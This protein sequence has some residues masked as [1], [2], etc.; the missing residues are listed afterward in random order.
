MPDAIRVLKGE[1][2]PVL[3][4]QDA[5][6][7]TADNIDTFKPSDFYGPAAEAMK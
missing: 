7:V 2:I 1:A 3:Q 5:V 6:M 4:Y